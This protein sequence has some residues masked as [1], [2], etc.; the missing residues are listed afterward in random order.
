MRFII[1]V[2]A[3]TL[4]W[5]IATFTTRPEDTETLRNFVRRVKPGGPG[6]A[7]VIDDAKAEGID[8]MGEDG[9]KPWEMP[10]QILCVFL[11]MVAVYCALFG[12]GGFVYGK[13]VLGTS[14]IGI[15]AVCTVFLFR[16]YSKIGAR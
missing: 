15:S 4:T 13:T 14:L 5:V 16:A 9:K 1:A 11:G 6:W 3:T 7:K 10:V 2:A 8:L 12:I